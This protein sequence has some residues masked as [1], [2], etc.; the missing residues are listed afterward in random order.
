MGSS[1]PKVVPIASFAP[2]TAEQKKAIIDEFGDLA[3]KRKPLN[4]RY[5]QL[6]EQILSWYPDL[7][8]EKEATAEGN[9]YSVEISPQQERTEINLLK[10]KKRLGLYKFL[11][12]CSVTLSKLKEHLGTKEI[13][14]LSEKQRTGPRTLKP[15]P[16]QITGKAA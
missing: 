7:D 3:A 1:K 2:G 13:E 16:K 12:V 6:R 9:R 11:S 8:P 5:D 14:E 15:V 10:T 4:D